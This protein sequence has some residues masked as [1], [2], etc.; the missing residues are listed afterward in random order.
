MPLTSPDSVM[1]S[2]PQMIICYPPYHPAAVGCIYKCS[3]QRPPCSRGHCHAP[4]LVLWLIS[5]ATQNSTLN[6]VQQDVTIAATVSLCWWPV[7]WSWNSAMSAKPAVSF[8]PEL[9]T[10][11]SVHMDCCRKATLPFYH[12]S[13]EVTDM[14]PTSFT[15]GAGSWILVPP[16]NAFLFFLI[17]A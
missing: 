1:L 2:F 16:F 3:L 10:P 15:M 17:P 7:Q 13:T 8:D 12:T 14:L 6:V 11:S 4:V 5:D 9:S